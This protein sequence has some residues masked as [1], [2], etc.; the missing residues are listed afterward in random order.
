MNTKSEA[1]QTGILV[2]G[3]AAAML[4]EAVTPLLIVRLLGKADVGALAGLMLI[5]HTLTVV[6]TADFPLPFSTFSPTEQQIHDGG[7]SAVWPSSWWDLAH[8]AAYF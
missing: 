2:L 6:L 8:S 3:R 5:Y 7:S 1:E 4:A